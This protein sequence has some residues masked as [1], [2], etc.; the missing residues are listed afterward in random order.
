MKLYIGIPMYNAEKTI[1]SIIKRC[2][3]QDIHKIIVVDDK[4]T[5]NSYD[6]LK[7]IDDLTIIQHKKNRG[8]GGAQK[9]IYNSFLKMC[10][11]PDDAIILMHSDGQ[12]Y[13]EEI[14]VFQKALSDPKADVVL[15]SRALG[16][17]RAG[18]MPYYKV[19]GDKILTIIQNFCYNRSLSTY[20]SGYRAFKCGAL[21]KINFNT[22]NNRHA[23]DSDIL[24][25]CIDKN[26]NLVEVPVSTYYGGEESQYDLIRYSLS[27]T[28]QAIKY[29]LK[30]LFKK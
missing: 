13:P 10:K 9:T 1:S 27:V 23:F 4:S 26:L 28:L 19:I 24:R 25:D 15:G 14:P 2:K 16:N 20:T 6:V 8:Y 5:D 22:Y 17:A 29:A 7:K 3:K 30:K 21:S 12:T 18:N 11:N